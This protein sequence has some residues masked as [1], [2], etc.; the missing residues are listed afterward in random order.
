MFRQHFD[1]PLGEDG[2]G[3]FVPWIV[4]VMVYLATL[5][6]AA[7]MAV[8]VAAGTEV[9]AARASNSWTCQGGIEAASRRHGPTRRHARVLVHDHVGLTRA[10]MY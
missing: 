3:R 8:E 2:S 9:A 4:A 10:Y 1:L 6:V 7:G 5:S